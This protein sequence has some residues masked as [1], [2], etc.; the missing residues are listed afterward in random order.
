MTYWERLRCSACCLKRI[1]AAYSTAAIVL[2]NTVVV[3][4]VFNLVLYGA[5]YVRDMLAQTGEPKRQ[6][7]WQPKRLPDNGKLFN[8]DGSPARTKKRDN[9]QLDWFDYNAYSDGTIAKEYVSDLLDDF[10]DHGR[11]GFVYQPWVGFSEAE[12]SGKLLHVDRD[13][14]GF[15]IR[16]TINPKADGLPVAPVYVLGG[17]TTFGYNV[18]DEH[19]WPTYLSAIL[20]DKAKGLHIEVTNYGHE[21][22]NSSQEAVLLADLLK[23]GHR[24]SLVVFMDGVNEPTPTDVPFFT[25]QAAKG[26]RA[27]QFPPSFA[28]RFQWVPAVRL[29]NFFGR[30]WIGVTGQAKAAWP[31]GYHDEQHVQ[32]S[33]NGFCQSRDIAKAIAVLY[34]VPVLFFLQ[35]NSFYNYDLSLYR[36]ATLSREFLDYRRFANAVYPRLKTDPGYVDL[37][38]MFDEWGHR[39]AIVDDVHYTPAFNQFL[40][41]RVAKGIDVASL[42][43]R[44]IDE[45]AATGVPR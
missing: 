23:S 5:V 12:F 28:E 35:P 1:K 39:K 18:A 34:H 2:L 42:K 22:F 16:R 17:S 41:Q 32:T 24:P 45:K 37:S 15:P 26:F 20:N 31:V 43:P 29:A 38:G 40:A 44:S 3:I 4:L 14:R 19:T 9:Y 21:Y 30:R 10:Y 11:L 13:A 7:T 33:L 27:A 25:E 36:V 8:S 6:P